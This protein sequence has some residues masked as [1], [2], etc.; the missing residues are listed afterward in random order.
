M[1]RMA[2]DG[3]MKINRRAALGLLGLGAAGPAMA[4]PA[5]APG[6]VRDAHGVASGDP[7]A[8]RLILWTR[9]L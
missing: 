7:L 8:D 2:G 4:A 1:A 5:A 9:V 3:P 6:D